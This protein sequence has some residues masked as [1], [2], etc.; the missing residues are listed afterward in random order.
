MKKPVCVQVVQV[1]LVW[2]IV[3]AADGQVR[4]F[5]SEPVHVAQLELQRSQ[6]FGGVKYALM[7]Q[8]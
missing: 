6:V 4:Q 1:V 3:G 8:V 5:V 7:M 2:N